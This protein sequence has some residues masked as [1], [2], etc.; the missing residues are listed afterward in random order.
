MGLFKRYKE[1]YEQATV[2][3]TRLKEKNQGLENA[4]AQHRNIKSKLEAD[5]RNSQVEIAE[6]KQEL[7]EQKKKRET[8]IKSVKS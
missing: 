6:L 4:L 7:E 3:I 8:I 1:K 2:D 5:L